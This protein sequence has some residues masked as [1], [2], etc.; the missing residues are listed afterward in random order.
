MRLPL[1]F[2]MTSEK[3]ASAIAEAVLTCLASGYLAAAMPVVGLAVYLTQRVYLRTSR[4]LRVLDL[5]AKAPLVSHLAECFEGR[6]TIRAMAWGGAVTEKNMGVLNVSQKPYYLLYCLQR[7]LSLVLDLITTGLATLMVGIAVSQ[8]T[9]GDVDVGYLGVGLV[10]VMGFGQTLNQLITHWTNLETSL[11]G[12][13]RVR[14][15][16]ASA[17]LGSGGADDGH[18]HEPE[19]TS[20]PGVP[21]YDVS[22]RVPGGII[23]FRGVSARRGN[24]R[25]LDQISASFT[26]GTKTAVCGR[27]G[28]GKSSLLDAIL[29]MLP[30]EEGHITLDGSDIED[31]ARD[32]VRRSVVALPQNALLFA[33]STVRENL[34]PFDR[35]GGAANS[36]AIMDAL[37]EVGLAELVPDVAVLDRELD[38]GSLSVGQAQLFGL[39]RVL[40]RRGEGSVLLLD[41]ATSK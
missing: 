6:V 34:D 2:L 26:P 35:H 9:K 15:Y 38:A 4:Q 33:A 22:A 8:R 23:E 11:G 25:V 32:K 5:E 20:A 28:S 7:W 18:E 14:G 3:L 36:V 24:Q 17:L 21:L 37:A 10:S 1:S 40:L 39:A 29:R 27:T 41:E 16:I 13:D 19:D 30:L 31:I 12:V